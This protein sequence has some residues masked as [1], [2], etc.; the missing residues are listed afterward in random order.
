MV[1]RLIAWVLLSLALPLAA[2]EV[3]TPLYGRP[4][5]PTVAGLRAGGTAQQALTLPFVDDFATGSLNPM[6]WQQGSG[7]TAG[8]DV[9]PLAPTVGVL[10]L[11]AVG[12]DGRL[13]P[14]A[15]SGL[16]PADTLTSAPL[17]LDGMGVA[18]SVV[19]SFYYLP[20]GGMGNLWERVGYAPDLGDTLFL[21]FYAAGDSSWHTVWRRAGTDVEHLVSETG[22]D[23]QYAAVT[24]D[25]S[26]FF[27]SLFR[28]RFRNYASLEATPKAGKAGNCD[29]WHVDCIW[30]DS[31]RTIVE[32][33][34]R[35]VAFA[36]P[37]GSLL[38]RYRAMPYRQYVASELANR[39]EMKI[40]NR[41]GSVLTS[42]YG[43]RVKDTA[44]NE[45]HHYDGG[46]Q[47]TPSFWPDGTYQTAAVHATPS[48][49]YVFPTMTAPTTYCVEHVVREGAGG[50]DFQENDTVRFMQVFD[51]YFAYDDGT[52]EN[53]YS[54]TSTAP[55]MYLA[56]RFDLHEEDTLTA[57]DLYFNSTDDDANAAISFYLTVWTA[58]EDGRPDAVLYRDQRRRQPQV[59]GYCRYELDY[60]VTVN[61]ALF[62][63]FEQTGNDFIN[64]GFDRSF[65]STEHIYYLTDSSWRQS[66]LSGSLL[67]R[68]CFGASATMGIG[69]EPESVAVTIH[70]NPANTY[71][72]AEGD[73]ERM[74]LYDLQGR[75]VAASR[76]RQ[77]ATDALP[78]G[79]YLL[80]MR[81]TDGN[82]VVQKL[83]VRH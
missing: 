15:S 62:V 16:F 12:P 47:N 19:L 14:Q 7:A 9:S 45:L 74:E 72:R 43:Y 79:V 82:T 53:G 13:Y 30:L 5:R 78:N 27:D 52:P 68:P 65:N 34:V 71:V 11:D 18:D 29:Y 51:N 4:V 49:D 75:Q 26:I 17:H 81:L 73:V 57:V 24:V 42:Q 32:H 64:L 63:G 50:D 80:R 58:G 6:R 67:L 33:P 23:W 21:D 54:L 31:A 77:M 59:G 41:Y 55:S 25:S 40:T 61:G 60:G 37:A 66:F 35:D 44:G 28:F 39:L 1:R 3:L 38:K 48:V 36:A 69:A 56:Y 70:P 22:R 83:I 8:F 76:G 46:F 2:Q 20:G 10:T